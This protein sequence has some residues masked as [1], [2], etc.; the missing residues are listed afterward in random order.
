MRYVIFVLDATLVLKFLS[1][2]LI[3]SF[4]EGR[5]VLS[6]VCYEGR[7]DT[8]RILVERRANTD[9]QDQVGH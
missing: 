8:A 7:S 9:L 4:Q 3:F 5:T 6:L 2:S 1:I